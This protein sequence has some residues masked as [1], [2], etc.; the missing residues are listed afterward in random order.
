MNEKIFTI[1]KIKNAVTPVADAYGAKKIALFGSYAKGEANENS[2]I[3]LHLIETVDAWG[4]FKL[5][6]F[7]QDLETR[8]GVGV[9]FLTSGAM[10]R[11]V[12]EEV[13]LGEVLIYER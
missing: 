3:D 13:V 2:D 5:C 4:Y 12:R 6:G 8:L 1:E 7:R 10:D 9:D 11:Q